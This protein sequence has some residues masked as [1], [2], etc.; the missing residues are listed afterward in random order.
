MRIHGFPYDLWQWEEFNRL[1]RPCGA[2]V[3]EINYGTHARYDYRFVR[4][5]IGI[6][7]PPPV[8]SL[9]HH[10][11]SEFVSTTDIEFAIENA[12]T[13]SVHAW[14]ERLNSR[15]YHSGTPFGIN[16]TSPGPSV[17]SIPP[18]SLS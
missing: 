17:I 15:P 7:N 11:P 1:F 9:T 16:P 6:G 4:V 8:H 14:R 2:V 12:N 13:E 3:L 5:R 18:T 10:A